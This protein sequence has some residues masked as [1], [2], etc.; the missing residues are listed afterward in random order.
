MKKILILIF[1]LASLQSFGQGVRTKPVYITAFIAGEF[2]TLQVINMPI[3]GYTKVNARYEWTAGYFDT[4]LHVPQYNGVP[5]GLRSGSATASGAIAVD[6]S[7]HRLYFYSGGSWRYS[8]AS[9]GGGFSGWSLSGNSINADTDFIGTTNNTSMRF[10]TNNTVRMVLDSNG[11]VGIGTSSPSR[12]F[13]VNGKSIFRDSLR[14]TVGAGNGYVLT[15]DAS[16]NATWTSPSAFCVTSITSI[17]SS[18]NANGMTLS[19]G[20]LN[21]QPAS[22]SYGGVVTTGTQTYAGAKT[23]SSDL[24][25]NSATF[26]TGGNANVVKIGVNSMS[27]GVRSYNTAVGANTLQTNTS[28]VG[29]NTA[30]GY[31]SGISI[32]SAYNNTCVGLNSGYGITSGI[33]NTAL[34]VGSM[35]TGSYSVGTIGITGSY[36][37]AIGYNTLYY[38]KGSSYN[39]AIGT[40]AL[41]GD[42]LASVNGY[43]T[44][45][46]A[47]SGNGIT[48]GSYNVILGGNTGSS[49]ATYSNHIII[50]D[51]A[52]NE[53]IRIDSAGNVGIG[54]SSLDSSLTIEH[55]IRGKRGVR[56]D[57]LPTFADTTNYKPVVI[58]SSGTLYKATYWPGGGGGGTSWLLSGN[59]IASGDAE[60]FGSTNNRTVIVKTNNTKIAA[61]DSTGSLEIG[62]YGHQSI[63]STN[64]AKLIVQGTFGQYESGVLKTYIGQVS[65][66]TKLVLRDASSNDDIVLNTGGNSYINGS[67]NFGV[68][69]TSPT[70]KL[71]VAGTFA[72]EQ[73]ADVASANNLAVVSNSVEIT[74]TTQINLI[75]NTGWVNGS[76]IH[77]IFTSTP[78]VKNGQT[79]SGSNITIL[80]AGAADFSATADDVLTLMLCEVGGTQ[81]WREVSRSVN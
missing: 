18:P 63:L 13:D 6:T 12:L 36:N 62:T 79:T 56:F 70:T 77:L 46:G 49:I 33:Q 43:N 61:W 64:D 39:T 11:N 3:A 41:A 59:S 17:G 71:Q 68:S 74:G 55:G 72:S 21:L 7:N 75:A 9:T 42:S 57:G 19:G 69:Q 25:I 20:V 67:G 54:T 66:N 34:G 53:R 1:F 2:K 48:T 76:V 10:R 26:G 73:G 80:L 47:N 4:A 8:T 52:G 23:F 27:L 15:S 51:G 22:A 37:V 60:F 31:A 5:S 32:T 29:G 28:G 58:N 14:Y 45:V 50:S 16:G 40:N 44:C 65:S 35:G 78:T 24:T 30:I 38:E 81:A